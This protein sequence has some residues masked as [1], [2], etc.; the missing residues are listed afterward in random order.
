MTSG[1][2]LPSVS[3]SGLSGAQGLRAAEPTTDSGSGSDADTDADIDTS[4]ATLTTTDEGDNY[5]SGYRHGSGYSHGHA[6]TVCYFNSSVNHYW[7]DYRPVG[8]VYATQ[9]KRVPSGGVDTGN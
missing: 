8:E 5:D 6:R 3:S 7:Y 2:G 1:G 4:G 9:V